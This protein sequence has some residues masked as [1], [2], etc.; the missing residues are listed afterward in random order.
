MNITGI[1]RTIKMYSYN[2]VTWPVFSRQVINLITVSSFVCSPH[3][4]RICCRKLT[5]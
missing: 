2:Q 3:C 4:S 5:S 1:T